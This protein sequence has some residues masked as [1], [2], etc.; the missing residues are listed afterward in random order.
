MTAL[1]TFDH[2]TLGYGHRPVLSDISFDIPEGDFLGLVGPNGA[3]KTTILR[4]ILGSLAPMSGRVTVR[5]GLRFGYVPQRDSVSYGFPL[6]VLDVVMMGRYD[7]IGLGRR[8]TAEDRR[9]ALLSLD[10]VGIA[11]L[12]DQQVS[13]LSGGQKQRTLIARALVGEPTVLVLDEPTNGMD[14]VSTTQ[15]LGLVRELHEEDNLTVLM[16][17]HA[18]NEVANYVSRIALVL[19]G[20]FRIG[21]V[22]EIMTESTLSAMYGIPV[23]V[24][25]FEGHRIVLARRGQ[26]QATHDHA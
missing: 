6:K 1:V 24:E 12:A 20:A 10:H 15:I 7:R 13:A 4:A 8:P 3:G 18:L 23:D 21:N 22:D 16:V 9:L 17:S 19:E 2:A 26:G 5:S 25:R 11:H 14:L